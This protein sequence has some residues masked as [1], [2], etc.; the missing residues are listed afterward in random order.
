MMRCPS[1][2]VRIEGSWS[3]CPLCGTAAIG[4]AVPSPLPDVPLR[5]SRRRLLRALAMTSLGLILLSFA[6]QLL[7]RPDLAAF[8]AG[9]SVWMG[10]ATMWLV[11]L[12]ATSTRGDVGKGT[13][14]LVVVAGLVCAYWDYLTGWHRWSV[15]FAVP[16]M[17]ACAIL[18]LLIT[19]RIMRIA[20]GDHI[21]YSAM[22]VLLGLVPLVFWA[23]GWVWTPIP[24]AI[25]GALALVALGM[26][27]ADGAEMR[28]EL[29][30]KLHL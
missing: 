24:S 13:V 4:S 1:C 21:L 20:V 26:Q 22:T 11:V 15:T 29:A 14:A 16:I 2:H 10:I 17:C 28:H 5:Y 12:M 9:R 8:G 18:A 30:K 7:F 6:A 23:L 25:C 19:V 3:R 27:L